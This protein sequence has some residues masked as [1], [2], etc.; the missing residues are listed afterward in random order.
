[1]ASSPLA[2]QNAN[3]DK[4]ARK[5]RKIC[6]KKFK[7]I[8]LNFLNL[9]YYVQDCRY[10]LSISGSCFNKFIIFFWPIKA[11]IFLFFF[12]LFFC[13]I[14]KINH[15]YIIYAFLFHNRFFIICTIC[16]CF[17]K[18]CI[19]LS[20]LPLKAILLTFTVYISC[21]SLVNLWV[22][23][24]HRICLFPKVLFYFQA[25]LFL[26]NLNSSKISL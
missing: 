17:Y 20:S 24:L 14:T 25:I 18:V 16:K 3:I 13:Y 6:W 12:I 15:S 22:T 21:F 23:C 10:I 9:Q 7:P 2:I 11:I 1:M 5:L 26:N 19:T 4:H 8:W